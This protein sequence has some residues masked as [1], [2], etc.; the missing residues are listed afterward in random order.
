MRWLLIFTASLLVL[1]T[2]LPVEK[3]SEEEYCSK[4]WRYDYKCALN[5][6]LNDTEIQKVSSVAEKLKGEDCRDTA[7]KILEWEDENLKYDFEKAN[8]PP[9]QIVVRGREVEV[10]DFGRYIQ[11]PYETIVKR[12]GICTDYAFLTLALLRYNGCEGYLVNVTFEK[13]DVGHVAAAIMVN[14]TYFILDQHLPPFDAEGYFVKWMKDGKKIER[15]EIVNEN[16]TLLELAE[17]YKATKRDAESLESRLCLYFESMG[18]KRD[19][20]LSG[21]VLPGNYREGYILKLNLEMAEYYH[22]E[23]EKQYSE[24]IFKILKGKI[25]GRYRAFNIDVSVKNASFEVTL[26]LAR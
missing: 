15:V 18:I 26:Y 12:K 23:F 9:P 3:L 13:D 17:G 2:S 1:C 14:G 11:T 6:I 20:K 22:P 7:W 8:L 19:P 16:S 21:D 4:V 10:Y 5:Y 25:E 24:H